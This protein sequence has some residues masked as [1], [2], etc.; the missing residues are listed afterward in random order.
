MA[1]IE[2]DLLDFTQFA[3]DQASGSDRPLSIDE[4]FD[5]WRTANPPDDDLLAIQASLRDVDAGERGKSIAEHLDEVRKRH[6]LT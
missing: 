4:L 1:S 2:N 3:R 5:Q 6:K